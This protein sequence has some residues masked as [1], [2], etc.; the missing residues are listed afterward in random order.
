MILLN[1]TDNGTLTLNGNL[2]V[3]LINGFT[4]A[5]T[6]VF[7]IVT[8][9]QPLLGAFSNVASGARLNIEGGAGSFI[10]NYSG[11]NNVTL[12]NFSQTGSH[13]RPTPA[14]KASSDATSSPYSA[15]VRP[16]RDSNA[17]PKVLA[18][19]HRNARS[20]FVTEHE[21]LSWL[22]NGDRAPYRS[23]RGSL[24]ELRFPT[25][26]PFGHSFENPFWQ[27]IDQRTRANNGEI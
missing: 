21:S 11:T 26:F 3:A 4:P 15:A 22:P 27:F 1:K 20:I 5:N 14:P 13:T 16:N 19:R 10:V 8:T 23:R 24:R 12:S 6:D 9:Q 2:T 7:T 25:A 18:S 17:A